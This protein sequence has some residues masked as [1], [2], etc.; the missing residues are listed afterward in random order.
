MKLLVLITVVLSFGAQAAEKP[1]EDA[2][3]VNKSANRV[4]QFLTGCVDEQDGQYVLLDEQLG[5]ITKL[6]S[7]GS[8]N[9]TFARYVGTR[10][11]I[12]GTRPSTQ[13]GL[14]KVVSIKQVADSCA[15]AK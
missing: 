15:S 4:K 3:P 7:E 13:N 9:D 1:K 6:K 10:V 12:T 11:Q 2:P 5:R 8:D 14:F